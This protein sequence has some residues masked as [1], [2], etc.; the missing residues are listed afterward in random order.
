MASGGM[1]GS[2]FNWNEFKLTV[3]FD[4]DFVVEHTENWQFIMQGGVVG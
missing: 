3:M 4:K 1:E 2:S